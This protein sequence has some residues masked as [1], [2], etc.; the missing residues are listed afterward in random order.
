M[1]NDGHYVK[2]TS[3]KQR[4][5][6]KYLEFYACKKMVRKVASGKRTGI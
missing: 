1:W 5:D 4:K 2:S 6:M 3:V